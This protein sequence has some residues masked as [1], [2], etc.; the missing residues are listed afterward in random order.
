MITAILIDG[1]YFINRFRKIEPHNSFDA[2]RMAELLFRWSVAHLREGRERNILY[3][4]FFYDC[5]PLAKKL[6]NPISKHVIDFS[7][8]K[9]AIFRNQLHSE[10]KQKRKVALRLGHLSGDSPWTI[11]PEKITALLKEQ[12]EFSNLTES[13]VIPNIRQK[14]VDM[15]IGLD[16]S[17]LAFKKQVD[18]IVLI[19][20]D[21]DFVPAAKQARREGI[22]FVLDPMWNHIPEGL[23]EH[24]DGL[25]SS[26]P[27]PRPHVN[28]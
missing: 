4:I 18:Q 28:H 6:H 3:R 9:E 14:G 19:A 11:R 22:D 21:A 16:I 13:D 27:K 2:K 7:K 1:A 17:S 26:C 15:R 10:L 5:P 25:R 23:R 24:I 12:L 8:S 20:G